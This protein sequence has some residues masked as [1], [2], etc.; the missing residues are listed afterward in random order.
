MQACARRHVE[1]GGQPGPLDLDGHPRGLLA[2]ALQGERARLQLGGDGVARA[3]DAAGPPRPGAQRER[4]RG[5]A[6]TVALE[7]DVR[8][9]DEQQ[10]G[11]HEEQAAHRLAERGARAQGVEDEECHRHR[12]A[13]AELV[14]GRDAAD[15]RA[16]GE[17]GRGQQR[18]APAQQQRQDDEGHHQR[19]EHARRADLGIAGGEHAERQQRP[20]QDEVDHRRAAP[21]GPHVAMV[22]RRMA[23]T[24]GVARGA[25][26]IPRD[27]PRV[28]RRGDGDVTHQPL[29]TCPG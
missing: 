29:A 23:R 4:E 20:A 12:Q 16:G 18:R 14:E 28:P 15:H 19:V 22:R 5:E 10:A 2:L 6:D 7:H 13:A 26:V 3:D 1:V 24:L 27:D 11:Q 25:G 9:A 17:G 8:V 21:C